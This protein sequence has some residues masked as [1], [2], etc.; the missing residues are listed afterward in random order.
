[1]T[2]KEIS[3]FKS[4][5][6]IIGYIALGVTALGPVVHHRHFLYAAVLLTIA[7]LL[8]IWEEKDA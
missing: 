4:G 7:E 1:M 5:V 8:G 2:H 6:R 3:Y